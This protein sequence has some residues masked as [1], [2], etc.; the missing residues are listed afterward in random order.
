MLETEHRHGLACQTLYTDTSPHVKK[1][2][3]RYDVYSEQCSHAWFRMT[4]F[5]Y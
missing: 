4:K 2:S 3:Y 1:V 5:A